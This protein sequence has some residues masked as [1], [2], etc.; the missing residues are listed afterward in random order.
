MP[1]TRPMNSAGTIQLVPSGGG[2]T[3]TNTGV[4]AMFLSREPPNNKQGLRVSVP[5]HG[6]TDETKFQWSNV[7]PEF[8]KASIVTDAPA[9]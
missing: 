2:I 3:L 8:G 5:D 1:T 9:G 4:T 7:Q 6:G